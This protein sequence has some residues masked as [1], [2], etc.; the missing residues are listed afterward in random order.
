MEESKLTTMVNPKVG[1][2]STSTWTWK[3]INWKSAKE[4]VRRLQV[5]IAK[6][7]Q[8]GKYNKVKILQR[9]LTKSFS[10][11]VLAIKRVTEN[12]GKNTPGVDKVIWK[13]PKQKETAAKNFMKGGV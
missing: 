11:T 5:R 4:N 6:A 7:T 3:S 12:K 10:A 1:A 2:P 13:T 8:L 9:L